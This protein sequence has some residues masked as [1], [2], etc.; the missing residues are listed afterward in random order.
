[1]RRSMA[2][3]AGVA[4]TATGSVVS[5]YALHA[6]DRAAPR[7]ERDA[8]E[9]GATPESRAIQLCRCGGGASSEPVRTRWLPS[10]SSRPSSRCC[11]PSCTERA[12]G[13]VAW[14]STRNQRARPALAREFCL[15][16]TLRPHYHSSSVHKLGCSRF[17]GRVAPPPELA[18]SSLCFPLQVSVPYFLL[19]M[20]RSC[21]GVIFVAS[22][23]CRERQ[24]TTAPGALEKEC[25]SFSCGLQGRPICR[26]PRRDSGGSQ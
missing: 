10:S 8:G 19:F 22:R 25:S 16:G 7:P 17:G 12:T 18:L 11:G 13:S 15:S 2:R 9:R 5:W 23:R 20:G 14:T 4:P 24:A 1:M 21:G 3:P 6:S 26:I